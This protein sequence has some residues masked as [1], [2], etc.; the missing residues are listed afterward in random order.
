M[1]YLFAASPQGAASP[2]P[3]KDDC[4]HKPHEA[5]LRDK[6]SYADFRTCVTSCAPRC[7]RHVVRDAPVSYLRL[8]NLL[9][10]AIV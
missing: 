10:F 6:Q 9:S 3:W 2:Q 1:A 5:K 7:R 8:A 4:V